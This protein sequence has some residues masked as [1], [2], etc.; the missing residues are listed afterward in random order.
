[1]FEL[2][3]VSPSR[4]EQDR[5]R[6]AWGEV[7]TASLLAPA[8]KPDRRNFSHLAVV[9]LFFSVL[10]VFLF[11]WLV[12]FGWL[13]FFILLETFFLLIMMTDLLWAF[14]AGNC[15]VACQKGCVRKQKIA[16]YYSYRNTRVP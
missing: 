15:S 3:P 7:V 11:G 14:S 4:V 9:M 13:G 16:L 10:V 1:M 12:F 5:P 8:R 6:H 2:K